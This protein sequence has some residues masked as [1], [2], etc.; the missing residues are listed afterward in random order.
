MD[1]S[2]RGGQPHQSTQPAVG[3]VSPSAG[4]KGKKLGGDKLNIVNL[5]LLVCIAVLI[6][7]VV[8]ATT[9]IKPQG[10]DKYVNDK[11]YQ[12]VFLTNGQVYFGK[13]GDVTKDS[14]VLEDIYY[15]RVNQQ[16]QPNQQG[17]NANDISLVK[18]GC[19][20]HGPGDQMI[21]NRSQVSFWENLKSDGSVAKAVTQYKQQNPNGQKCDT[22]SASST[23]ASTPAPAPTPTPAPSTKK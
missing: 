20:L 16:V 10:E 9:F 12:A 14:V 18:L 13:I 6:L 8:A 3:G 5:I 21:I 19:E 17:N 1:F 23:G 11:N 22:S 15:L 2:Q 4:K 7:G